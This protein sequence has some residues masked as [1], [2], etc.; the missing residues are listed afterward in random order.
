MK[1]ISQFICDVCNQPIAIPDGIVIWDNGEYSVSL[2]VVH[3]CPKCRAEYTLE[4]CPLS[5]T[6]RGFVASN[7]LREYFSLLAAA[8]D[9]P[10]IMKRFMEKGLI[11]PNIPDFLPGDLLK[12]CVV[13][14]QADFAVRRVHLKTSIVESVARFFEDFDQDA[15]FLKDKELA[16]AIKQDLEGQGPVYI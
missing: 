5:C 10:P 12:R 3:N 6:L 1:I 8:E 9:F 4:A 2:F 14:S 11:E 7:G 15:Y 13:Q 16:Q